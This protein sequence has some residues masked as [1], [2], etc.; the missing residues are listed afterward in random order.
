LRDDALLLTRAA[1]TDANRMFVRE[2]RIADYSYLYL[3]KTVRE[4]G[5]TKQ[6]IIRNLGRK[7]AVEARGDLDRLARSAA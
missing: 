5:R 4:D 7:E 6:R 1:F 3:V 2:K